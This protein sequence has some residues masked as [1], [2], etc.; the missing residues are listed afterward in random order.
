MR[1]VAAIFG[2]L[3]LLVVLGGCEMPINYSEQPLE[4]LGGAEGWTLVSG[5]ISSSGFVSMEGSIADTSIIFTVDPLVV[6]EVRLDFNLFDLANAKTVT[7]YDGTT[8]YIMAEGGYEI[9]A[10]TD[11]TVSGQMY[12]YDSNQTFSGT[13]TLT[14]QN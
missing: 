13:F 3:V 5:T 14:I 6:G 9:T 12:V 2:V 11:T 7:Y 10:I 1:K 8:N 4:G